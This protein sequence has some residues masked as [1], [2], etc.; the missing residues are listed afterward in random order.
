MSAFV[1]ITQVRRDANPSL[2][3]ALLSD[4][5]AELRAPDPADA[6]R[7]WCS[8]GIV[9]FEASG[10]P[11]VAVACYGDDCQEG[12]RQIEALPDAPLVRNGDG[13]TEYL[14]ISQ[15]SLQVLERPRVAARLPTPK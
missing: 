10:A 2:K 1:Y 12:S 7:V 9:E 5:R 3:R 13:A 4:V 14:T 6:M 8:C 11:I 15:G